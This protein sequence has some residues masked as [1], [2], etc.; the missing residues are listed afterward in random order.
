MVALHWCLS[1]AAPES[2][3][4]APAQA[5]ELRRTESKSELVLAWGRD[6]AQGS[7]WRGSSRLSPA[8]LSPTESEP[9]LV[10]ALEPEP[11]PALEWEPVPGSREP[12]AGLASEP[13]P[14]PVSQE[15]SR[16]SPA[17]PS[18]KEPEPERVLA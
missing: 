13:V 9:E 14:A 17:A 1:E 7:T 10:P 8:A 18:L 2:K 5:S 4:P 12:V 16:H 15:P 6:S 11:V 3:E